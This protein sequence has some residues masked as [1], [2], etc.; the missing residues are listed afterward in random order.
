MLISLRQLNLSVLLLLRLQCETIAFIHTSAP[1]S[2]IP[3]HSASSSLKKSSRKRSA[4]F[5]KLCNATNIQQRTHATQLNVATGTVAAAAAA[6]AAI[7]PE[8]ATNAAV[9]GIGSYF[10]TR[11]VFLRGLAFVYFVAFLIA[12]RQNKGLIGDSGITPG[13]LLGSFSL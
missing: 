7:L 1:L 8:V 6:S 12:Y 2:I 10:L 5:P 13:K 11:I 4:C 3:T 9:R